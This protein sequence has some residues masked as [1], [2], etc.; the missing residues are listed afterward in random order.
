MTVYFRIRSWEKFQHYKD[1]APPWIKLHREILSSRTWVMLDD[2]A[3]ALAIAC[4]L[5]AADTDNKVPADPAY[6]KRVAYL[7]TTPDLTPLVETDFIELINENGTSLASASTALAKDTECSPE[8]R[9]EEQR[10]ADIRP[11]DVAASAAQK[12]KLVLTKD[13]E[14]SVVATYHEVLPDLPAVR[15][16]DSEDRKR[17]Q[18]R[19]RQTVERG[20]AADTPDYW[21]RFFEKVKRS[22]FLTGRSSDWRCPGLSWMVKPAN[23]K[24]IIN[25][26]YDNN[27]GAKHGRSYASAG[28]TALS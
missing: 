11:S 12:P 1:R 24:K 22:D 15:I 25:G 21:R 17:L 8:E 13:F 16:W 20:I 19:V 23:F 14:Q 27:T 10:R 26:N 4:M 9:R 28:A 3:K 18:D 2:N 6:I 5:L 7:Q